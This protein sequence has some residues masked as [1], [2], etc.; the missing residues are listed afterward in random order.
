[1]IKELCY[2]HI[3]GV[4]QVWVHLLVDLQEVIG[5]LKTSLDVTPC[6][7]TCALLLPSAQVTLGVTSPFVYVFEPE[8]CFHV[9]QKFPG[10][11]RP[12]LQHK[13]LSLLKKIPKPHPHT[14]V[15]C[16]QL[17]CFRTQVS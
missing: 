9:E 16:H 6:E 8:E 12:V 4:V 2:Q 15:S 11:G 7:T 5:C 3:L 17:I 1:M 10:G 14:R 13:E